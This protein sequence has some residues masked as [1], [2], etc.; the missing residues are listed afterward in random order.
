MNILS[1]DQVYIGKNNL[2]G[3]VICFNDQSILNGENHEKPAVFG[4]ISIA[5]EKVYVNTEKDK[6]SRYS[7]I[8]FFYFL[9]GSENPK[10]ELFKNRMLDTIQKYGTQ[11]F[12]AWIYLPR[13]NIIRCYNHRMIFKTNSKIQHVKNCYFDIP[14][15][16]FE[17]FAFS[18]EDFDINQ[19]SQSVKLSKIDSAE[20]VI[21]FVSLNKKSK[22]EGGEELLMIKQFR[23]FELLDQCEFLEAK[24]EPSD[25]YVKQIKKLRILKALN[26]ENYLPFFKENLQGKE[27]EFENHFKDNSFRESIRGELFLELNR[28]VK[29]TS[30]KLHP[31]LKTEKKEIL[32]SELLGYKNVFNNYKGLVKNLEKLISDSNTEEKKNIYLQKLS[33]Y[34]KDLSILSDSIDQAQKT[35]FFPVFLEE[36]RN[37]ENQ[38][39][40]TMSFSEIRE[41]KALLDELLIK[42]K[43]VFQA[44][45]KKNTTF[46]KKNKTKF[47]VVFM[48]FLVA[49]AALAAY[50]QGF[51]NSI[52]KSLVYQKRNEKSFLDNE[53]ITAFKSDDRFGY[54]LGDSIFIA[55]QFSSAE[56][57]IE[58]RARVSRNDSVFYID[59][60]GQFIDLISVESKSKRT[61]KT[62]FKTEENEDNKDLK[63]SETIKKEDW[64]G[65]FS[66]EFS[67][68]ERNEKKYSNED[69]IFKYK[70]LGLS[71][72]QNAD[73]EKDILDEKL[74]FL[75]QKSKRELL[76]SALSNSQINSGSGL[77]EELGNITSVKKSDQKN[78][79]EI[80]MVYVAG[81]TFTMGCTDQQGGDCFD[82]EKPSHQV[83]LNSFNV[84]K[85]EITQAQWVAVMGSNPSK[86]TGCD[87]CPVDNISW[88]DIQVFLKKLNQITG[89]KYRLPTEAE[90]EYAARGG[91][92]SKAY[93]YSGSNNIGNVAWTSDNSEGKTHPVGQKAPNELGIYDLSGNVWEWCSDKYGDYSSSAKMNPIGAGTGSSSVLRGGS[94]YDSSISC[95]ISN[96]YRHYTYTRMDDFGFRVVSP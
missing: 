56:P 48:F 12:F 92:K 95:R 14:I 91:N 58:N 30:T 86:F 80:E 69:N 20:N 70:M 37:L 29:E 5:E 71:I 76:G 54:K 93:R 64:R 35:K 21:C 10:V 40:E 63:I 42:N 31:D 53:M 26:D 57:F 66:L 96:R 72:P 23:Y 4:F 25:E 49:F 94:W 90:W 22:I 3:N 83:T 65:Q 43:T 79:L 28:E 61:D 82:R 34:S 77:V 38:I 1:L 33:K 51:F 8:T 85:Y 36:W 46:L 16:E 50:Q 88:D 67:E 84:G 2:A 7:W 75:E 81:G 13:E 78:I 39:T 41:K 24:S 62:L 19:I 27:N 60:S 89:K 73:M 55:A 44:G 11:H 6:F 18:K 68:I 87:S 17:Y 15:E 52:V 9:D 47:L 74:R 45:A 32:N 59:R